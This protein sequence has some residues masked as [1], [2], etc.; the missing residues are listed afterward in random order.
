MSYEK[1]QVVICFKTT[2]NFGATRPQAWSKILLAN[3]GSQ[4]IN[5][6]TLS[7]R[8]GFLQP[9]EKRNSL[10]GTA[11]ILCYWQKEAMMMC[12]NC[13]SEKKLRTTCDD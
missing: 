6:L 9:R 13:S 2:E 12:D 4:L 10:K 5:W 3:H 7:L 11:S 8:C 1:Q